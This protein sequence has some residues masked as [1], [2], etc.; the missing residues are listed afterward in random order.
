MTAITPASQAAPTRV[1]RVAAAVEEFLCR[2][3]GPRIGALTRCAGTLVLAAAIFGVCY[4]S[5]A[6]VI[7]AQCQTVNVVG[8]CEPDTLEQQSEN[9]C[10]LINAAGACEDRYQVGHP[11]HTMVK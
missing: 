3:K 5:A 6:P 11:A 4:T 8:N 9:H 1:R 10:V 7:S 2:N